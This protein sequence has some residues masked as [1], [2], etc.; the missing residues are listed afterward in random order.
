MFTTFSVTLLG[1]MWRDS[2]EKNKWS[3]VVTDCWDQYVD[4]SAFMLTSCYFKIGQYEAKFSFAIHNFDI[5]NFYLLH[6]MHAANLC[7]IS[8]L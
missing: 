7:E 2:V 5:V 1:K 4:V 8:G 6:V 3:S